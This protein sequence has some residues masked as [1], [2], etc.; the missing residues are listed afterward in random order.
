MM[1]RTLKSLLATAILALGFSLPAS[2]ING[3]D[4][5]DLWWNPSE[6]GWGLNVIHQNGI[7]FA[8]L[9][10]YDAS[11]VP[12]FYSASETRGSGAS[13]TGPLYETRGTYWATNPYNASSYGANQVGSLT[14]AFSTANSG[15]LTYVIGGNTIVKSITRFAFAIDNLSGNYLGGVT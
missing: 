1:I 2:A 8:T 4:F 11:G 10:V 5:S 15:T 7:I 13:F 12:H 6:P 9:Y 3:T 14:L